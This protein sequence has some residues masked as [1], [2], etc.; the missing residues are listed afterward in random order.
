MHGS[1]EDNIR[2]A[3]CDFKVRREKCRRGRHPPESVSIAKKFLIFSGSRAK[4]R[5]AH[6]DK[7]KTMFYGNTR[8]NVSG[9]AVSAFSFHAVF[10]PII[11]IAIITIIIS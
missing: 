1:G 4:L 5:T 8:Q 10:A 7:G 3:K 2:R 9:N 11:T 6:G